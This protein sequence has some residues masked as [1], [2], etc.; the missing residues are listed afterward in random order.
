MM[1]RA[2]TQFQRL[3]DVQGLLPV[4]EAIP[5]AKRINVI[6]P[7]SPI[8]ALQHFFGHTSHGVC[9]VGRIHRSQHA[10]NSWP[11]SAPFPHMPLNK[12]L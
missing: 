11:Y 1:Q 6:S 12:L 10:V 2:A 9:R 7:I 8:S 5:T 3:F 4:L